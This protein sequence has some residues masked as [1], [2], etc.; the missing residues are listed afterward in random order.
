MPKLSLPTIALALT[1]ALLLTGCTETMM[2]GGTGSDSGAV[3]SLRSK[4]FKPTA[5]D[6]AGQIIAMTYSG[7]VTSAV[8]CGAKGRPK[9]PI[10]PQMTDL[11]G[12]AKRATLDAYVI[13]NDGRVVSGIYALV[14]RAKGKMPEGIDFAPGESKAFASGLT[15][16][17]A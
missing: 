9:A 3:A 16:T 15:C 1:G 17:N 10:A 5:R 13:L 12:T 7:P 6:S 11:D 8:V 14:L 4:G 2:A